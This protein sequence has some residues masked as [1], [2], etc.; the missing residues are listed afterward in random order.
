MRKSV[1]AALAVVGLGV[2]LL[3]NPSVHA[4]TTFI[5]GNNATGGTDFVTKI[6]PTS[7]AVVD[8]FSNLTGGNG[9]GV[10]VVNGIMYYTNPSSGNV[11][12]YN[13]STHTN[14]GVAF[15][16][17][18]TSALSAI[19][20]DGTNFWVAD[21]SGTNQA[22]SYTPGG[23]LLKTIHLANATGNS[24]G[25]EYFLQGGNTPRLIAN[26]ADGCCTNPTFY[27]VYDLNGNV[28]TAAFI[29]VADDATG[30]AYDGTNFL[31]SHIFTA[32]IAKYN[33]ATGALISNN[34]ITGAPG[35]FAPTIEDLSVDY[36]I[37]LNVPPS[38]P[39]PSTLVL[40]L[41]GM[42]TLLLAAKLFR[43]KHSD[44]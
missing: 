26:R 36:G 17:A 5:Y 29:T 20:F 33:G 30:I 14:T 39:A 40:I 34:T 28:T 1:I 13:I 42:V 21:Y 43:R 7:F 22:Y 9:R 44:A 18:G 8:T 2:A 32:Q 4:A 16:I 6:D 31:V 10:V 15:S 11:Y 38:S 41:C 19:A 12:S 27:D 37:T 3:W 35:G 24:D 23:T 25:L